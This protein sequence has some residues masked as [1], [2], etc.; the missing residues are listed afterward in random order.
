GENAIKQIEE[1]YSCA[2]CYPDEAAFQ[3]FILEE[4]NT[5]QIRKEQLS[6][7]IIFRQISHSKAFNLYFYFILFV[8]FLFYL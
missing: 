8:I 4:N 7:N 6:K 1:H 3:I 2:K 5:K